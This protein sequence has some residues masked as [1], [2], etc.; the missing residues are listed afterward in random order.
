M[1]TAMI[2]FLVPTL[3]FV[4]AFLYETYLSFT[5]LG[6]KRPSR[7]NYLSATWEVTHT[8]LVFAVVMLIMLFTHSLDKLSAAIFTSTFFAVAALAVRAAAYLYIFYGRQSKK[9]SWIDWV[10][11]GSHVVAAALLVITVVKAVWFIYQNHPLV[12]SQFFPYFIPGLIGV[13]LICI[14][15]ITMLYRTR[16]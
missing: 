12:N 5:R 11:A 4:L 9:I 2:L 10:F 7:A 3:L 8:L 6:K 1:L 14:V 13:L 15:P 16:D